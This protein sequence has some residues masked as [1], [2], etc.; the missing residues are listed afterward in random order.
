MNDINWSTLSQFGSNVIPERLQF[1][2]DLNAQMGQ[3]IAQPNNPYLTAL[4]SM[5]SDASQL[6][7][8]GVDAFN[9][10]R[11][12]TSYAGQRNNS[13]LSYEGFNPEA[14]YMRQMSKYNTVANYGRQQ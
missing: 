10:Q 11:A 6:Y 9:P 4:Q 12:F 8:K 5:G 3:N 13:N 2:N 7:G 1:I 14:N